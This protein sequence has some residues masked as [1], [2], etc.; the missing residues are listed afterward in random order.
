MTVKWLLIY[1]GN[2]LVFSRDSWYNTRCIA[3]QQTVGEIGKLSLMNTLNMAQVGEQVRRQAEVMT[4]RQQILEVFDSTTPCRP[5][6]LVTVT[7]T[8]WSGY[9]RIVLFLLPQVGL[10]IVQKRIYS[11][12]SFVGVNQIPHFT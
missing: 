7:W 9:N 6:L 5:S 4:R 1:C 3:L 10:R 12:K 11:T 8:S 2:L